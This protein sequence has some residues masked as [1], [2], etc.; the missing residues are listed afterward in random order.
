MATTVIDKNETRVP[1]FGDRM[2]FV[3]G[4]DPLGL[5][6]PSAQAYSFMLPGLNNV[7]G[8]IRSYCF[9]CWLLEEYAKRIKSTDP[10]EQKR[11]MRKAEYIIALLS[12]QNEIPGISGTNYA[13]NRLRENF[14]EFDLKKGIYNPDG[15]T[16][17]TYWQYGFGIF[18]QY[19]VGPMRQI[20][21]LDVPVNVK[22][23]PL[24]IYRR[25]LKQEELKV[26][27]IDLAHAFAENI[28]DENKSLL[29]GC[30]EKDQVTLQQLEELAEDFNLAEIPEN[31]KEA[32]LLIEMLMQV[33][34]PLIKTEEP[35]TMRKETL[36]HLLRYQKEQNKALEQRDFTMYAYSQAGRYSKEIDNCLTGWYYYQF[37]EYWQLACTAIFNGLLDF[38][39][40]K[41]GPGWTLQFGFLNDCKDAVVNLLQEKYT[42][43]TK[44]KTINHLID[45]IEES[46]VDLY[47]AITASR[48][49]ERMFYAL[50]LILKLY[51][52]NKPNL[53]SLLEY[54]NKNGIGGNDD[55]VAWYL[56]F[57]SKCKLTI[58]DFI[59]E[60]MLNNIINRHQFVAYRKMGG[61]SQSTQKFIIEENHLR[62]IGN[63]DPSFTSPR[64][65]RLIGFLRD[66][67]IITEDNILSKS[68]NELL[69]R[70]VK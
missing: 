70:Y 27:G 42:I 10:K 37:N 56:D 60:F 44:Q 52:N 57:D 54:T 64:V 49:D 43:N 66:L 15:S 1:F 4:L 12:V 58:D 50:L 13:T 46:E 3:T 51:P 67:K 65:G 22:G 2:N 41:V 45:L 33:D 26:S 23:E 17:N 14:T 36:L 63:F 8:R 6:N 20:G 35:T 68:G 24:G 48:G 11:F 62:R 47:E 21:L 38:L 40:E 59:L 7:T 34:E 61:G 25:T 30:I 28:S 32:E 5:Q 9:Y 39:E 53:F 19:Y 55:I 31:T 69:N 16:T 29:L 18:G